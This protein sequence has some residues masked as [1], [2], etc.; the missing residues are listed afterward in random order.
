[1]S[2]ERAT[3][4]PWKVDLKTCPVGQKLEFSGFRAGQGGKPVPLA[5][6]IGHFAETRARIGAAE[7][8]SGAGYRLKD[9]AEVD[10]TRDRF[11]DAV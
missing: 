3:T 4:V 9:L 5:L 1:M 11:R 10:A 6:F 2:S 7:L 8:C